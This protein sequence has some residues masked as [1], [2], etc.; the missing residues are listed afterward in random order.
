[1]G[2]GKVKGKIGKPNERKSVF[3]GIPRH[4][5]ALM[6]AHEF[7]NGVNGGSPKGRKCNSKTARGRVVSPS[8]EGSGKWMAGRSLLRAEIGRREKSLRKKEKTRQ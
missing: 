5:P 6:R 1:M 2:S 7:V 4:L 8:S 3:D